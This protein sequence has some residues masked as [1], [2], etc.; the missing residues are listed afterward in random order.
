MT[1]KGWTSD[2]GVRSFEHFKRRDTL[3]LWWEQQTKTK[4]LAM[5]GEDPYMK[6][7]TY[8]GNE[9]SSTR[10]GQETNELIDRI[11]PIYRQLVEV[12]RK[13]REGSSEEKLSEV[14]NFAETLARLSDEVILTTGAF[15][16]VHWNGI[17]RPSRPWAGE[18]PRRVVGAEWRPGIRSGP[19]ND[20]W[21]KQENEVGK[22]V[23]TISSIRWRG[24]LEFCFLSLLFLHRLDSKYTSSQ[25]FSRCPLLTRDSKDWTNSF[26][27][28]RWVIGRISSH[29]FFQRRLNNETS[30]C[31]LELIW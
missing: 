23:R 10:A 20:S 17:N 29:K 28:A 1:N 2:W 12:N 21:R 26:N 27:S 18:E 4:T 30:C 11:E 15:T 13:F 19:G 5:K 24:T 6:T 8:K 16:K 31:E 25:V 9:I 22:N 3:E 14:D 7:R